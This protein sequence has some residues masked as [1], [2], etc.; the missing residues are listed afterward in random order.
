[1]KFKRKF[2]VPRS[3]PAA[4]IPHVPDL[5]TTREE[6]LEEMRTSVVT[7]LVI[8][9]DSYIHV[10]IPFADTGSDQVIAALPELPGIAVILNVRTG[11]VVINVIKDSTGANYDIIGAEI[12]V[13]ESAPESA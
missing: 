10:L 12:A 5:G 7:R 8:D 3:V 11:T 4:V 2:T 13:L 6:Q 1:M 9:R